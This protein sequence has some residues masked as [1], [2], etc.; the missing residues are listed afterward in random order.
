MLNIKTKAVSETGIVEL[1]DVDEEALFDAEGNRCSITLCS[2]GSRE[3]AEADA[4][5]QN[6]VTTLMMTRPGKAKV[7]AEERRQIDAQFYSRITKSFN[8]WEYDGALSGQEQFKAAYL[9]NSIGFIKEQ[10]AQYVGD[11]GNFKPKS[12]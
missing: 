12:A 10:L 2:P 4:E 7:S 5:R 11:W 1:N 9:D 8:H 6:R 3:Y